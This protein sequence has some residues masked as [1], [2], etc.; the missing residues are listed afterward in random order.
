MHALL[1]GEL[2]K[3]LMKLGGT[4]EPDLC[5]RSCKAVMFSRCALGSPATDLVVARYGN[6]K[7]PYCSTDGYAPA[8]MTP[9]VARQR[10]FVCT[11]PG[12]GLV[13]RYV[14]ALPVGERTNVTEMR[15]SVRAIPVTADARVVAFRVS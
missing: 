2:R 15:P 14:R 1:E 13:G 3:H 8:R 11:H 12:I 5:P 6:S 4:D 10:D 7:R 9:D